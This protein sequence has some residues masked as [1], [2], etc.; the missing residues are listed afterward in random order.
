MLAILV[1]NDREVQNKILNV[2]RDFGA[3]ELRRASN[4]LNE[5]FRR[6]QLAAR[7]ATCC[8]RELKRTR[9]SMNALMVEAIEMAQQ[10]FP[11]AEP[12]PE[13]VVA[14]E[15]NLMGLDELAD[16]ETLEGLVRGVRTAARHSASARPEHEGRRRADLHRPRVGI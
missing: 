11:E 16:V 2:S 7:C 6:P 14:G 10:V 12:E 4:Y 15:T 13:F 5:Q 3:D 9:A 8:S 1:V